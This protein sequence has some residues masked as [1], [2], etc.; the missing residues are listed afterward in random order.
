MTTTQ[1]QPVRTATDF[2]QTR[3]SAYDGITYRTIHIDSVR[4]FDGEESVTIYYLSGTDQFGTTYDLGQF[5][6]W[7]DASLW[8]WSWHYLYQ[9][10]VVFDGIDLHA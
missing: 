9:T 8:A 7:K 6:R 1:T 4:E 2:A 10:K 3:P 5:Y